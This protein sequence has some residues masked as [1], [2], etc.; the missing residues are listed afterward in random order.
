[1]DFY[2]E[3]LKWQWASLLQHRTQ[4]TVEYTVCY[5]PGDTVTA[6]RV[7]QISYDDKPDNLYFRPLPLQPQQLFR[8]AIGR[9]IRALATDADVVW[10]TDVDYLFGDEC[11]DAAARQVCP[12][13][14]KLCMPGRY[15]INN[16]HATGDKM[17]ADNRNVTHPKLNPKLFTERKQ[18]LAIGGLQIIGG[19]F[20]RDAGY[21]KDTRYVEPVSSHFGF[22]SC[23]CD[24]WYRKEYKL[25]AE[26]LNI[27]GVYRMRHTEAGRDY[28][29]S[30]AK[31]EQ[32]EAW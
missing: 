8:R 28:F 12:V 16:D 27:P 7:E 25:K 19:N 23:K 17:I 22:R 13:R 26:R 30:G 5:T 1:M 32:K 15:H 20:A 11:L 24:R 6:Q 21:L 4:C 14:S 18:R 9:N 2:A 3:C 10:M 31:G 29:M